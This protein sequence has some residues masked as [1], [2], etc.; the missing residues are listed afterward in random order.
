MYTAGTIANSQ[1]DRVP[2]EKGTDKNSVVAKV[3]ILV[4]L[5]IL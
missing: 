2:D 5:G 1:T 4:K 3:K